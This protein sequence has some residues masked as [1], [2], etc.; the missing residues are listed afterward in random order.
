MKESEIRSRDALNRYLELVKIDSER[1]FRNKSTFQSNPCP[2]CGSG[3]YNFQF[4]KSGF[5]FVQCPGCD[6]LFVNPRPTYED[7]MEIYKSCPSTKFWIEE[8]FLP[9]VEMRREK[10]FKPRARYIT[11]TF[12]ELETGIIGDI[13]AGFGIFLEELTGTWNRSNVMAIEPSADMAVICR[14]KGLPVLE[15]MVEDI[16]SSVHKF[17]LLTAFELFEHLH[18]PE[19]FLEKVYNLLKPSGYLYLTTLNGLGFDIQLLWERSKSV[20]PPHHLNF[21]NPKSIA[22]LL[23]RTGFETVEIATP[24]ELDWD[25]VEAGYIFEGLDPGRFFKTLSK[26]GTD[27]SKKEL[28]IWIKKSNLSSH[29]RVV[30]RRKST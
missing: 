23:E 13:G 16:D 4:D 5:V 18:S 19:I 28:Q 30:A 8:F 14:N 22:R 25:I 3:T 17:D 27:D 2:A 24:G 26:H 15:S 6:T 9:K 21:L 11:E 7:L 1:I 12:P 29:M 10:I 20:S